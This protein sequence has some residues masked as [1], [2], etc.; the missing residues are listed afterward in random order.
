[1]E[2]ELIKLIIT[3]LVGLTIGLTSIRFFFRGSVLFRITA[4]WVGTLAFYMVL[5]NLKYM[6]PEISP[7]YVTL[8]LGIGVVVL[9]FRH[10][11]RTI[12]SPLNEVVSNLNRIAQGDL[13]VKA[14][15]GY[16]GRS[17]ELGRLSG[18]VTE[19]SQQ[20]K[21][22]I[23]GISDAAEDIRSTGEQLRN[24]SLRMAEMASQ[25]AVSLEEISASMEEIVASIQ[26]N[27]D[28]IAQ[29]EKNS[30]AAALSMEEGVESSRAAMNSL[31][32]IAGKITIVNDIAFQ[33]NLLALNAAVEA[34]RAGEQGRGFAV[35]AAEVRRL[36]DK[37]KVAASEIIL[38]AKS[39]ADISEKARNILDRNLSEINKANELINEISAT[40]KEQNVGT[41]MVNNAVQELNAVTQRNS[42]FSAE[43]AENADELNHKAHELSRLVS[44]FSVK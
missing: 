1:M 27:S 23:E 42:T 25:Q 15:S 41:G 28:N 32:E 11:S 38:V 4:W 14:D 3:L 29:T 39:G 12:M 2:H 6:Y 5:T 26:Q 22:I 7:S 17:D 20:L 36:A 18:A 35:V 37:S 21:S 16:S 13:K 24:K 44:Y 9:I 31:N 10:V 40:S 8:P 34:A 33:T 19:L 30:L 43:L